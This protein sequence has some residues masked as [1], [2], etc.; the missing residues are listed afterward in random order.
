MFRDLS[1]T[2][3]HLSVGAQRGGS[4]QSKQNLD[5]GWTETRRRQ[6]PNTTAPHSGAP[7]HETQPQNRIIRQNAPE[8]ARRVHL[9]GVDARP[10][11]LALGSPPRRAAPARP[12][13][14]PRAPAELFPLPCLWVLPPPPRLASPLLFYFYFPSPPLLSSPPS[15]LVFSSGGGGAW[16]GGVGWPKPLQTNPLLKPPNPASPSYA[17]AHGP[18]HPGSRRGAPPAAPG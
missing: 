14:I 11:P 9:A 13:E 8:L 16:C 17:Y 1:K 6:N 3:I 5:Q 15:A 18:R 7:K 10:P 4:D 2:R 12:D